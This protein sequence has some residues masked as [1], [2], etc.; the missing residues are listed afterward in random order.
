MLHTKLYADSPA[1]TI[2]RTDCDATINVYALAPFTQMAAAL[3]KLLR[4]LRRASADVGSL[5]QQQQG[6]AGFHICCR[7]Y[8]QLENLD[9]TAAM[10]GCT[11]ADGNVHSEKPV[12][13]SGLAVTSYQE[14]TNMPSVDTNSVPTG[15]FLRDPKEWVWMPSVPERLG[16]WRE[17]MT[18]DRTMGA[19]HWVRKCQPQLPHSAIHKLFRKRE[20]R[21][22]EKGGS[23]DQAGTPT[24]C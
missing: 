14:D 22:L 23:K 24:R 6:F 8:T 15:R 1:S 5:L 3:V 18:A 20:V 9:V 16:E 11:N 2:G 17:G 7:H 13:P 4:G 12:H 10:I 19:F 21:L